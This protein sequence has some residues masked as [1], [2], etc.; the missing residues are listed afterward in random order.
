MVIPGHNNFTMNQSNISVTRKKD[1]FFYNKVVVVTGSSRGIGK[2]TALKFLEAGARVVI[3]GRNPES[4]RKTGTEFTQLGFQPLEVA[5]DMSD[6]GA[7]KRLINRTI[8]HFG[9]IDILVNNAGVGFR[10]KFENTAPDVFKQVIDANLMSAIYCTKAALE[11]VKKTKGSIV[12]ISA[13]SGVLGTPENGP[14]NI[15]KMG[16]NA[17]ARTLKLE[18]HG[19]GVH[20]GIV[21]VGL[22]EYDK[23][24]KVISYVGSSI[25][26]H[27]NW[28][29]TMEQAAIEILMMVRK[30]KFQAILTT[31]GKMGFLIQKI[32]PSFVEWVIRNSTQ[33]K[34]YSK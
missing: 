31:Q 20:I 8:E 1:R 19:T 29:Q 21:M 4:L 30:R 28:H 11:L 6:F 18:M 34:D 9:R 26:F 15:A 14:Y 22:T 24:N 7:C 25:P 5:G 27:R 10:G 13:L 33:T 2:A 17:L 23:D 12:F 3:N 32:S 16:L